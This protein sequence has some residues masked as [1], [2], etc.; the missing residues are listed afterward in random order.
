M[1]ILIAACQMEVIPGR[2]DLNTEKILTCIEKAK[3]E[4][5]DILLFPELAVPGYLIGDL[6]EQ[7]A[8]LK[9]CELFGKKIIS[10][11]QG[12]TI[13]FGNIAVDWEQKNEDGRPRKYNAAFIAQNGALV[14]APSGLPFVV[15]NSLPNYREFDDKR[16]FYALSW[17][18][19]NNK[20]TLNKALHP[21]TVN[22]KE[23]KVKLGVF[24]CEDGWTDDYAVNVPETLA[25]H[26]AEILLNI[27]CSPF[28]LGKNNKRNRVFGATAKKANL[29][30]VYCNNTG[31]QN[32]GK[33]IYTYD[34]CSCVYD[35]KGKV[36]AEAPMFMETI[37]G[38]SWNKKTGNITTM[39]KK[40]PSLFEALDGKP[41]RR[42]RLSL[43]KQYLRE[44][45]ASEAAI[46]Y[47]VLRYGLEKFLAQCGL[48]SMVVGV[49]GGIDSAVTAALYADILGP[50][51]I[52]LVNMPSKYNSGT[53]KGLAQQ[54]AQNL[55]TNYTIIPIQQSVNHT[56]AQLTE[57]P[58]HSYAVNRD[59]RLK[60]SELNKENIQAR[61]RGAR[62]LAAVASAV[63]GGF[64]CNTN[65]AELTVGYGTFYGDIAGVV[66]PLGDLWKHQVYELGQYLNEQ[67][68]KK[69]V[70]PQEVFDIKPS[71]E[72]SVQQTVGNGGDP[73][74]Y[75]YHDYLF[76]AFMELWQK[77]APED[78]LQHYLD[79]DIDAYIGC[80][81]GLTKKLFPK[82]SLFTEDLERWFKL[83]AGFAVAKRIQDPPVITIS[84]RAFGYDHREAQLTPYYSSRYQE[85][86][87]LALLEEE[88]PLQK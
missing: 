71:A 18:C 48:K 3:E 81:K 5:I 68:Y 17:Y 32:N 2:P 69:E 47:T 74:I 59:F 43:G 75:E 78:L 50:G 83:F 14:V 39:D 9:D 82:V 25:A 55:K 67:V 44:A 80:A 45:T 30:V 56:V 64:S 49:S 88:N 61:D 4:N 42:R 27:S 22:I 19:D 34:G 46:I 70:I 41:K 36:Q 38:F 8:F 31:I 51:N 40:M 77:A 29:P 60:L 57:N 87:R 10:A 76:H 63:N 53:T 58:I 79:D 13:V 1:N 52:I 54:L 66:A 7:P 35:R 37:L 72:L 24:L 84:R 62:I 65:K 20:I 28:T 33:N 26:G 16:H 85:L 21:V 15:K 11:A 23:T 86:K 6:W 12:I 73:L